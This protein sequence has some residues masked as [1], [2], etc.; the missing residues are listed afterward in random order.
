MLELA[1]NAEVSSLATMVDAI[2]GYA[3]KHAVQQDKTMDLILALDEVVTNVIRHGG[4]TARDTIAVTIDL[5]DDAISA[6]VEDHG[7]AF[8][9][10]HDAPPHASGSLEERPL[11]G[12]GLHI[13][14]SIMNELS[15]Q[16]VDGRN[17]LLMRLPL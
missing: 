10:L 2:E 1:L 14:R 16:R 5:G 11:G 15:Y 3:A 4:L 7:S 6:V 12:L 13:V 8:D 9:P 17:R